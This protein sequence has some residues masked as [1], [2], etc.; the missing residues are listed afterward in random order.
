MLIQKRPYY[1]TKLLNLVKRVLF[2]FIFIFSN[3]YFFQLNLKKIQFTKKN[4]K[5]ENTNHKFVCYCNERLLFQVESRE[6]V[7]KLL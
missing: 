7:S 4:T 1:V 3:V 2:P 5:Y 6:V